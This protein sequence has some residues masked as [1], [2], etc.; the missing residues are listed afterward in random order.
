MAASSKSPDRYALVGHPVAHSRSPLIHQLFARQTGENL[1][2]ELIDASPAEFETAVR[3]FGAA[4]GRGINVTLPHKEAAF[5][6]CTT[7]GPEAKMAG[8]VNTISIIGGKLRGDNT[9]G[10]GFIRDLTVN[11][12]RALRSRRVLLLGAG[13][14]ARGIVGPILAE[15]PDSLLIANRTL[16][17]AEKLQQ[18]FGSPGN[19]SVCRF[20]DLDQ[21]DDF[22]IVINATSAGLHGEQPPFPASLVSPTCFCYDLAYSLKVTPFL[23]WAETSGAGTAVQGWGMLVEQ[24]AE[25]FA[26][27]RGRRPDTGPILETIARLTA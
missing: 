26:I 20:D 17:R 2:Y 13:G 23:V 5:A 19:F 4:G 15:R 3:G 27:W 12:E 14:A 16:E 1:S 25:S 24:A 9:D 11:H 22:D 6:L 7:R 8:A 10:I 18:D 21:A